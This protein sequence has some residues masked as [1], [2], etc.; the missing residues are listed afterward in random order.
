[1][2]LISRK[3]EIGAPKIVKSFVT[4]KSIR[5]YDGRNSELGLLDETH[6]HILFESL[7][8]AIEGV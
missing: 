6:S 3:T 7:K 8:T 2:L 5:L 4:L 1:M